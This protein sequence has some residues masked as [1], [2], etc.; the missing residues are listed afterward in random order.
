M[1]RNGTPVDDLEINFYHKKPYPLV[2]S[3][4]DKK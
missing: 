4:S 2:Y 1:E 3:Q